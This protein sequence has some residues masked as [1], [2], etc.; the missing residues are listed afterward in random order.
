MKIKLA[1]AVVQRAGLWLL[2][3]TLN[4]QFSPAFAQGTVFSYQ[5]RLNHDANRANG[6]GASSFTETNAPLFPMRF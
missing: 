5:G 2:L 1:R 3:T 6:S 4:L